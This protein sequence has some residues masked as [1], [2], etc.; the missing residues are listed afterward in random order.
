MKMKKFAYLTPVILLTTF[1]FS[2]CVQDL[3]VEP[4]DPNV[5]TLNN[6]FKDPSAYKQALAKLYASFAISGQTGGGGGSPDISGIDENFGN[7]IRQYWDLQE[8]P[9]DEA[10]MAWDDA[11]IKDFHWQTWSANDVFIAAL[12]SRIFYTVA[13]CNEFIRNANNGIGSASGTFLNDLKAYKAEA[14]FIRAFAYWHA[15]DLFGNV[16][17]V[18]EA[19]F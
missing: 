4:I 15:I 8:L 16:P 17:F 19:D 6:V 1:L 12:Y 5:N 7:Y 14:R 9:T 11:T 10:I 2:S 13:I 18:T 3:T